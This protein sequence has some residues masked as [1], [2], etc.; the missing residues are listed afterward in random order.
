MRVLHTSD[1]HFGKAFH[2]A[3]KDDEHRA[4]VAWLVQAVAEHRVDVVV[5]A[6]DVFDHMQPSAESLSIYYGALSALCAVPSLRKVVVVGGNHDS[7]ARIDAPREVLAPIRVHA[8]GGLPSDGVDASVVPIFDADGRVA[9]VV[10]AVPYIHEYRLGVRSVGRED[11]EI[12][13][14]LRAAYSRVYAAVADVCAAA[15]PGV[16][17]LA[18]GHMTVG[19]VSDKDYGTALHLAARLGAMPADIFDP[20]FCY[21]ALGHLHALQDAGGGRV[22]YSG[23]PVALTER[24]AESTRHVLLVDIDDAAAVRVTPLPVPSFRRIVAFEGSAPDIDAQ[25]RALRWTEPLVPHITARLVVERPGEWRASALE[26][27][28]LSHPAERR[29]VLVHAPE[30]LSEAA[31]AAARSHRAPTRPLAELH[32]EEV[33]RSLVLQRTGSEPPPAL[34]G[35]FHELLGGDP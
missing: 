24:E 32:P 30:V 8:V 17:M 5:V 22:W 12:R 6:G 33:F 19:A 9:L 2:A 34:L 3:A 25:I 35:A 18:T 13:D 11:A 23:T 21:V 27:A 10:G 28:L 26:D 16:P 7:A 20:R 31:Q 29:P 4:F 14:D 1:W 15:A